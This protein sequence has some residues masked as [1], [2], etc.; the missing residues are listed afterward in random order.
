MEFVMYKI[1]HGKR[2]EQ[3]YLAKVEDYMQ[4][5]KNRF[6]REPPYLRELQISENVIEV[7]YGSHINFYRVEK[8]KSE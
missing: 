1:Y 3:K 5:I 7:D 4:F 2:N 8:I 6:N